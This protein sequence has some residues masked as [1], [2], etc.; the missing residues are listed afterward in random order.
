MKWI[1]R[2]GILLVLIVVVLAVVGYVMIDKIT[3]TAIEKGGTYAMGVETKLDDVSMGLFS[4]EMSMNGLS[5]ANPEGFNA[6]HF[7]KLGDGHVKVTVGSLMSDKVEVPTLNL[8][9][10]EI[11]LEKNKGKANY[12]VILENL[13][14]LG[15]EDEG[16]V[17][18][19]EEGKKFVV[20]ELLI[21]NVK[22]KAEVVGDLSTT[23]EIPE[24]K[25]T[26]IG[27]DSDKGVLLKDLSGIVVAAIL[28]SVASLPGDLLPGDI[29]QGLQ[30]GLE[31]IGGLGEFSVQVIGDVTNAAGEVVAEAGKI[32][33]EAAEKLG[34][35]VEGVGEAAKGI[36]EGA[37]KAVEGIGEGIGGL[38]GGKKKEE[39]KDSDTDS[40]E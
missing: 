36:G 23:I 8:N 25:L 18:D 10:I 33:G 17:Q 22:V 6:E 20:N 32:V 26:D 14:K 9:N 13:A 4:G 37:G 3:K 39:S 28:K 15:G 21:T 29:G 1:V 27:S 16:A 19:T 34:E 5:V 30:G 31:A 11:V 2:I 12:D 38:L 7:L 35:G 24:I 40:K